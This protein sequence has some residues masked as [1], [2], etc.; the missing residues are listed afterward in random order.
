LAALIEE[1]AT[2]GGAVLDDIAL[3]VV[4]HATG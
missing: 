4:E 2:E 3:L 1:R